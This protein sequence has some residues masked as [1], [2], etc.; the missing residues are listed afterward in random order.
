MHT[1]NSRP[2]GSG[3]VDPTCLARRNIVTCC[4]P[5]KLW[6]W[7]LKVEAKV[8]FPHSQEYLIISYKCVVCEFISRIWF[9]CPCLA[10][11]LD[12][13]TNDLS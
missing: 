13:V 5:L 3:W 7:Q 6:L 9:T 11:S 8:V 4:K 2:D 10:W 12:K 1:T